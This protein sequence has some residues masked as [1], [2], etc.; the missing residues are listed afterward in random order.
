MEGEG[1]KMSEE[2][3]SAV[4]SEKEPKQDKETL[5]ARWGW[6]EHGVWTDSMLRSLERGIKGGKWF[7]LI[8]KVNELKN[9]QSSFWKVWRNAGS[10]GI[11]GQ[12]VKSFEAREE[13]QLL[14]LGEELRTQSY[15]PAAVKRVWIPKPG[16]QEKRP[17]GIPVVRDRVVQTALRNVIEPIFE[18]DFAAQSYGFRPGRGTRDA[19]RRVEELLKEGNHWV[20]DADIKGYFDSIPHQQL[21]EKIGKKISDGRVL[22]LIESYL[23]AGVMETGKG[24]EATPEGT[25]QGG[26]ISPLLA[27]IYLDE[28]DWELARAGLPMVRYADDFVVLCRTE[29]EACGALERIRRWMDQAQLQL[30]PEKTKVVD[31]TQK[32]G[33]DFLGYHFERGQKWPRK[34]SLNRLREKL[35]EH[36]RRNNGHSLDCIIRRINPILRGWYNYFRFSKLNALQSV[37]GWIRGRLRSILRKRT[38]RKGRA[39]GKDHYRWRNLFFDEVGLFNLTAARQQGR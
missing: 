34:K 29:Q 25:P 2:N 26:V 24:W 21:M 37:D 8:D 31:A 12:S 20:V 10:A 38:K 1:K 28:L 22:Q 19:L 16:S 14:E 23:K 27:N 5:R 33:F 6:V 35:R 13:Q 17:L 9:L 4:T 32:G 39:K 3:L 18:R 30:H 15:R 11:D 7:A 36:T